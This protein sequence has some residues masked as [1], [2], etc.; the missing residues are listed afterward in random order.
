MLRKNNQ[1]S[2]ISISLHEIKILKDST[3][4]FKSL[5]IL[6]KYY[7]EKFCKK[8]KQL[9]SARTIRLY[10]SWKRTLSIKN[11]SKRWCIP[12]ED[13]SE[14]ISQIMRKEENTITVKNLYPF[15]ILYILARS[16]DMRLLRA[17]KF[18][19]TAVKKVTA[20]NYSS[21]L[22]QNLTGFYSISSKT[23]DDLKSFLPE[24]NN[25][26]T[27]EEDVVSEN[28]TNVISLALYAEAHG[29]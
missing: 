16:H 21:S 5:Y 14:I 3:P 1:L 9:C 4:L 18:S 29:K 13:L 20:G 19:E 17:F 25:F 11:I 24:T 22:L 23:L 2:Y 10:F 15:C 27:F 7:L 26:C 8:A 12:R 6:D 28:C